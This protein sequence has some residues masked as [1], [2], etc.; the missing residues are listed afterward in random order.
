M[1]SP[2]QPLPAKRPPPTPAVAA[3]LTADD[4]RGLI[5]EKEKRIAQQR[6]LIAQQRERLNEL[7]EELEDLNDQLQDALIA[8]DMPAPTFRLKPLEEEGAEEI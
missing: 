8:Q 3:A 4:L 2:A 1:P 6:A 5:A 7:I